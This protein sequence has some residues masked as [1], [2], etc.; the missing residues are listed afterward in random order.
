[1]P[2]IER[3]YCDYGHVVRRRARQILGSEDEAEDVLQEVFAVITREPGQF[4]GQSSITTWLYSVTTHMC[5][6]RLRNQRNR[7]R[8]LE[9]HVKPDAPE[10]SQ[11]PVAEPATL[12]RQI[13]AALPEELARVAVYYYMDE[14]THDEI[15]AQLGCSRRHVGDLLERFRMQ[16]VPFR[17][18]P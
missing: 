10:K 14:M 6:N 9:E 12:A 8:L 2:S 4:H 5:L 7:S 17:G 1:M 18:T 16:A 15:A 11:R 13:L 3:L